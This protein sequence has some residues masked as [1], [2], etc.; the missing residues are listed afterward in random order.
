MNISREKIIGKTEMR[1][2]FA[3]F[4]E[5]AKKGESLLISDRGDIAVALIPINI[6]ENEELRG[7]RTPPISETPFFGMW[8][9]RK[10]MKNSVEYVNKIRKSFRK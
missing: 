10:D 2:N 3:A 8:R 7:K 5:K 9:G 1:N 4:Y 6:L